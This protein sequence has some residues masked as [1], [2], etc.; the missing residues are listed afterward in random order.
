M[1][2]RREQKINCAWLSLANQTNNACWISA[3]KFIERSFKSSYNHFIRFSREISMTT[4]P[5]KTVI[6]NAALT[7]FIQKGFAGASISDIAK[8][9]KINQSL[10]YHHFQ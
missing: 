3:D 4:K 7:V 6:L 1:G 2:K 9:A 5:T 10:I 8:L